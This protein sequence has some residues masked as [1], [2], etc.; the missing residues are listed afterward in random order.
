MKKSLEE[1]KKDVARFRLSVRGFC[2]LFGLLTR[3]NDAS[4]MPRHT[5]L[6]TAAHVRHAAVATVVE[7]LMFVACLGSQQA[8]PMVFGSV[9]LD[10]FSVGGEEEKE[11]KNQKSHHY[12]N[13]IHILHI[14][15]YS[16][17]YC[18]WMSA[19]GSIRSMWLARSTIVSIHIRKSSQLACLRALIV[20]EK[21]V[22]QSRT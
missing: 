21:T 20:K 18:F 13:H 15:H 16:Y 5:L 11:K 12:Y 7:Q 2:Y 19:A 8:R 14:P 4:A 17:T 1:V 9:A 22:A 3:N 6:R 10:S